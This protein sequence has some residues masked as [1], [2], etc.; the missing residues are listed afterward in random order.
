[1]LCRRGE[2]A[3]RIVCYYTCFV[4]DATFALAVL[5][6]LLTAWGGAGSVVRDV[7]VA[8]LPAA[9]VLSPALVPVRGVRLCARVCGMDVVGGA[10]ST[11][12]AASED[13]AGA[14]SV[15]LVCALGLP[16][17][18][19]ALRFLA[20]AVALR[21]LVGAVALGL[22]VAAVPLGLLVVP[23]AAVVDLLR[24]R[25]CAPG[26]L[27]SWVLEE[28][29]SMVRLPVPSRSPCAGSGAAAAGPPSRHRRAAATPPQSCCS[30]CASRRLSVAASAS[31]TCTTHPCIHHFTR[32]IRAKYH[33][34]RSPAT[35]RTRWNVQHEPSYSGI[36]QL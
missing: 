26:G 5:G 33:H 32:A 17:V 20:G 34:T 16:G 22:L 24:L 12:S 11:V 29:P 31:S 14:A 2:A 27:A 18:A 19:V 4:T 25:G 6:I 36:C 3:A 10:A 8:L 30:N 21:L 23:V 1:M 13:D 9:L 35:D 28:E 7:P 15:V